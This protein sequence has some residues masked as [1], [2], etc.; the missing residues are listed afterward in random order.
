M[1]TVKEKCFKLDRVCDRAIDPGREPRAD[2]EGP[3]G[4]LRKW[5]QS[6]VVK[7]LEEIISP[8]PA[9]LTALQ[10]CPVL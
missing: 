4:R 10:T 6:M 3:G 7:R 2:L 9:F 8:R 1:L 5:S